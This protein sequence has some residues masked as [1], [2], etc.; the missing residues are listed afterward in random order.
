MNEK[1]I[2]YTN[3]YIC[4]YSNFRISKSFGALSIFPNPVQDDLNFTFESSYSGNLD[5]KIVD[6]KGV[7]VLHF[8]LEKNAGELLSTSDVS[9]F[10]KGIYLLT[11]SNGTAVNTKS[12]VK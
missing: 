12:F 10:P 7:E 1:I 5:V 3:I 6:A 8:V 9:K 11:I 2:F 4:I